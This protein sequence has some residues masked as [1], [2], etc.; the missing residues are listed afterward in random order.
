MIDMK[1]NIVTRKFL[2]QKLANEINANYGTYIHN[3]L[4]DHACIRK[5]IIEY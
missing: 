4:L 1:E 2:T 3:V 5:I